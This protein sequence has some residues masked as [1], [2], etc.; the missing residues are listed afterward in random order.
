MNYD[1]GE[2]D[3]RIA[4]IIRIGTVAALD[5][6]NAT[7][8]VKLDDNLTTTSL[9]W[10]THRAANTI[11]WSAPRVGEQVLVL[12]PSGELAQGVILPAI[13]QDLYP[14]PVNTKDRET[15]VYPDGSAVDYNSA[16]NTLTVTVSGTGNVIVNCKTAT[17]NAETKV[18]LSTPLV[19]VTGDIHADGDVV[20]GSISLKNHVHSDPQGG[21][22]G[23]P[24]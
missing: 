3:R 19:H 8:T 17:V 14:A 11:T 7:A 18:E 15:I 24:S 12:A 9:P 10:V 4:N 1:F 20:A 16:T 13:Y 23:T 6:V 21:N 22:T 5:E 2:L